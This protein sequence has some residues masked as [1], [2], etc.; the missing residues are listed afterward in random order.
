M[1][2]DPTATSQSLGSPSR[3]ASGYSS[4]PRPRLRCTTRTS[5]PCCNRCFQSSHTHIS[6]KAQSRTD[7]T[8]EGVDTEVP[9]CIRCTPNSENRHHRVTP[10]WL[11][12]EL[13][14]KPWAE[15]SS[16]IASAQLSTH[17]APDRDKVSNSGEVA[18]GRHPKVT[19]V[20]RSRYAVSWRSAGRAST[21]RRTSNLSADS[22]R[23]MLDKQ[24]NPTDASKNNRAPLDPCVPGLLSLCTTKVR[25][26]CE[27]SRISCKDIAMALESSKTWVNHAVACTRQGPH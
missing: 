11:E 27:Y 6:S 23:R 21:K 3:Y 17:P 22:Q 13:Y 5:Q 25:V 2:A 10:S 15:S 24:F 26:G 16:K 1:V 14:T 7:K 8:V 4:I 18:R 9:T 12:R 20:D 19:M